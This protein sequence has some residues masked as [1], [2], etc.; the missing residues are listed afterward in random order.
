MPIA[1]DLGTETKGLGGVLKAA[2]EK[3][4]AEA[5]EK[6]K[7]RYI[8]F[9]TAL[10]GSTAAYDNAVILAGFAGFFA[11]WAGTHDDIPRLLGF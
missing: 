5:A 9:H 11:L 2:S 1:G 8:E 4:Q 10:F 6:L 7:E 3:A